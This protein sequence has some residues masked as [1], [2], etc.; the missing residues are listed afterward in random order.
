[1]NS[2]LQQE[3]MLTKPAELQDLLGLLKLDTTGIKNVLVVRLA[4]YC[5]SKGIGSIPELKSHIKALE[6]VWW[7]EC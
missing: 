4:T 3:L 7:L 6:K 1:M 5:T 2:A